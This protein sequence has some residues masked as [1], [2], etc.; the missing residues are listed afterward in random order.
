MDDDL[1]GSVCWLQLCCLRSYCCSRQGG[2]LDRVDRRRRSE[3]KALL[4]LFP[5]PIWQFGSCCSST[6]L[7]DWWCCW[8]SSVCLVL[9]VASL[10]LAPVSIIDNIS[11]MGNRDGRTVTWRPRCCLHYTG[12]NSRSHKVELRASVLA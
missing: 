10:R 12:H 3:T 1:D 6:R 4:A 9:L 11:L 5:V 8:F 7:D 2:C